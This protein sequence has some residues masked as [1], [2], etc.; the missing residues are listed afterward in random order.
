MERGFGRETQ[1]AAHKRQNGRCAHCGV[2]L[3]WDYDKALAI[4]PIEDAGHGTGEWKLGVDNCVILCNGCYMWLNVEANAPSGAPSEPE[5][6]K[7]S[8]GTPKNGSHNEWV[9]RMRGR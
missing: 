8:H 2:S 3:V 4:A 9:T 1:S 5:D 6:F 7:F